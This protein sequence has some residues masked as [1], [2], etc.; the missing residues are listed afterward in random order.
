[1]SK[2]LLILGA[3]QYGMVVR[4]TAE[5][6]GCF[7][8]ISFLD[9]VKKR[10]V[11][12][13][14]N[15]FARF[16]EEYSYAFVA[17]GNAELR[18]DLYKKLEE[19][20]YIIPVIVNSTAYVSPSAKL[21]KGTIVEAGAVINYGAVV[22]IGCIISA[23]AVINHN[24]FVGECCHIDCNATVSGDARVPQKT[25]VPSNTVYKADCGKSN[26]IEGGV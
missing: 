18:L 2:N 15:E 14:L 21:G 5:A 7:D 9:D 17:I 13:G 20:G 23:N 1:M 6:M 4:E 16:S 24:S 12:G 3:G 11:I 8:K 19:T 26:S 22:S 25:K 10:G